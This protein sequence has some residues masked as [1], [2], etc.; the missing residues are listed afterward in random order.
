MPFESGKVENIFKNDV[1]NP[2]TGRVFPVYI[3]TING[4]NYECGYKVPTFKVGDVVTIEYETKY[5]KRKITSAS[6]GVTSAALGK[7]NNANSS[8]NVRTF[9]VGIESP[10]MSI[11]RQSALK[12]AVDTVYHYSEMYESEGTISLD[13]YVEK[14][15]AV[16]YKYTDFSSGQREVKLALKD[17]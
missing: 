15:L 16:A 6:S 11:I 10:E 2:K 1:T 3:A 5:G 12:S 14:V 4:A 8:T 17:E 7:S 9:P 13:D